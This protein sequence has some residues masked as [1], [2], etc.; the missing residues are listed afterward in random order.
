M[1]PGYRIMSKVKWIFGGIAKIKSQN[2]KHAKNS[3]IEENDARK[4]AF[5]P[6]L[7]IGVFSLER[8]SP[9][10]LTCKKIYKK[11]YRKEKYLDL[12]V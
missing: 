12:K 10:W 6:H 1:A 2:Y 3:G 4:I 5:A 8:N 9:C 11:L 7:N